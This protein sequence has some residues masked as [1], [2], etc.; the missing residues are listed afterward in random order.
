MLHEVDGLR[1]RMVDHPNIFRYQALIE[2]NARAR[3]LDA[4]LVKAVIAVESAFE[5]AAVST[6]GALG[7]M[8]VMPETG[9]RY[10]I[11]ADR[12]RTLEQK[13]LDPEI[14]LRIGTIYLHDLLVEAAP[15][16][17]VIEACSIAG[18]VADLARTLEAIRDRG[19]DGFYRGRVAELIV[20]EMRRGG[21]IVRR[22]MIHERNV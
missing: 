12:K 17:L 6:K 15:Q 9:T 19:K 10:G 18:W 2:K 20:A 3:G 13:L 7:L 14:N 16:R 11:A 1:F 21:G 5:P 4:A 8:Q 22:Q